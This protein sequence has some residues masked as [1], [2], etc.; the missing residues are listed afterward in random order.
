VKGMSPRQAIKITCRCCKGGG[1]WK[2][3]SKDCA[4][5]RTVGPSL[6]KIKA[7]CKECNGDDHSKECTGRLID[8]TI[9]ILHPFRLGKNPFC[10]RKLS[11][12]HREKLVRVGARYHF[13]TGQKGASVFPGS[14]IKGEGRSMPILTLGNQFEG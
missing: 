3:E 10:A 12:E 5:I 1:R 9:C 4:L 8:G 7:H 13:S 14:T 11:P 2:C 6:R